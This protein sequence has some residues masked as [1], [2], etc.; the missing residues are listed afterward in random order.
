MATDGVFAVPD[1]L[2]RPWQR[3]V[4][5]E[6]GV[7]VEA[8]RKEDGGT[9]IEASRGNVAF[10]HA[11]LMPI[12]ADA[13]PA[14]FV[15]HVIRG[16]DAANDGGEGATNLRGRQFRWQEVEQGGLRKRLEGSETVGKGAAD[17]GIGA[18]R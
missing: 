5:P 13:Q 2:L 7:C 9:E 4:L 8:K 16:H 1:S 11:R 14:V 3:G 12:N 10:A 17:G 15:E 6:G 18:F